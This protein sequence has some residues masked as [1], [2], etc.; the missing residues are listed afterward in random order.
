M[1]TVYS[2]LEEQSISQPVEV[3]KTSK[4]T[5]FDELSTRA[6]Q[7]IYKRTTRAPQDIYKSDESVGKVCASIALKESSVKGH[8]EKP[9]SRLIY[10]E[11]MPSLIRKLK[12]TTFGDE[13]SYSEH[14]QATFEIWYGHLKRNAERAGMDVKTGLRYEDELVRR[15]HEMWNTTVH[16]ERD[17]PVVVGELIQHRVCYMEGR[18]H[19]YPTALQYLESDLVAGNIRLSATEAAGILLAWS[20]SSS[21]ETTDGS[22]WLSKRK[23]G[24]WCALIAGIPV[25]GANHADVIGARVLSTL[26]N[27]KII[28][29]VQAGTNYKQAGGS[30][31]AKATVYRWCHV[32]ASDLG[33]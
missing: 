1:A 6:L 29:I 28:E 10:T 32:P 21:G 27:L 4:N 11:L 9:L 33:K 25:E 18:D 19:S 22:F 15:F 5:A 30:K 13:S 8:E 31:K 24:E 3:L 23:A 17:W 2:S 14:V 7:E 12:G 26:K 20:L 16:A